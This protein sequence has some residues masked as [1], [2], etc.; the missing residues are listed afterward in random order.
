MCWPLCPEKLTL[1][2]VQGM[3]T[4]LFNAW[5]NPLW[6]W[7]GLICEIKF[8]N[9]KDYTKKLLNLLSCEAKATLQIFL[10]LRYSES[11]ECT[12]REHRLNFVTCCYPR[13]GT[14]GPWLQAKLEGAS[15]TTGWEWVWWISR[16]LGHQLS[17]SVCTDTC[18][19]HRETMESRCVLMSEAAL[20]VCTLHKN[21][22]PCSVLL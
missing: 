18:V 14:R 12:K 6:V 13:K 16:V 17:P 19:S 5:W 1:S 20:F 15:E 8:E 11:E 4:S 10:V 7:I 22:A 9:K 21:T 3:V 2:E